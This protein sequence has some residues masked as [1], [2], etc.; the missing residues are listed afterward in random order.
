MKKLHD[1]SIMPFGQHRGKKLE[2]VPAYYLL[3]LYHNHYIGP[4][5]VEYVED[6][7]DVLQKEVKE[8]KC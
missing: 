7:L 3:W 4:D 6:N 1:Q 5:L 2:D 8:S